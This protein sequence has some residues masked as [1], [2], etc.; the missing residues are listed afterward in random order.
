MVQL[1]TSILAVIT[2]VYL[3]VQHTR[4]VAGIQEGSS[5]C[6]LGK[7]ADCDVVNASHHSELLGIPV[8]SIGGFFFFAASMVALLSLIRPET[9]PL[10]MWLA[11]FNFLA[12]IVDSALFLVQVFQIKTVCLLCMLT[13]LCSFVI[14]ITSLKI[15]GKG[16]G[17]LGPPFKIPKEL[18]RTKL[19]IFPLLLQIIFT[20]VLWLIPSQVKSQSHSVTSIENAEE[21][22]LANW[23]QQ[24]VKNI[25]L[26]G[27][28]PVFGNTGAKIKMVLF[29]DF[30]CPHCRRAA[31]NLHTALKPLQDKIQL[32]FKHFPLDASCNPALKYQLHAF[33]C[34]LAQVG[35]C[36]NAKNQFWDYHDYVFLKMQ[37]EDF[38]EPL[39]EAI[40]HVISEADYSQCM[41][42]EK[43]SPVIA[44]D[45]RTGLDI[46]VNATPSLFI[47]G[48]F[49]SIPLTVENIQRLIALEEKR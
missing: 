10:Q 7:Y 12:L 36:L 11:R 30:E 18:M 33:A 28:E 37:K 8:A 5:F 3:L 22:F 26:H 24:P 34:R 49:V 15:S 1:V 29:S 27:S 4:L 6:T 45:I 13:Y 19:W 9:I 32:H 20:G 41:K 48:R 35:V 44:K 31:F 43:N 2:C 47:N 21:Q 14:L 16:L 17:N 23:S 46:G 42:K 40:R 39:S 38:S 25:S